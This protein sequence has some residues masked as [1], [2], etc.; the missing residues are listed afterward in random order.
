MKNLIILFTIGMIFIISC[1][2]NTSN[3]KSE[4]I[5]ENISEAE[6]FKLANTTTGDV[7]EIEPNITLPSE[8]INDVT[9]ITEGECGGKIC[10]KN[11]YLKNKTSN[12]KIEATILTTWKYNGENRSET[13]IHKTNPGQ[14]VSLGCTAW[15]STYGGKQ[16]FK[17]KIIGAAYMK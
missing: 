5:I 16:V 8:A 1:S 7:I 12:K 2:S 14:K 9:L 4:E 11:E 6:M 17:R 13:K 3:K 15:C 10:G